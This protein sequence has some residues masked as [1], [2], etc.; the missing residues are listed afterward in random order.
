MNESNPFLTDEWENLPCKTRE[1]RFSADGTPWTDARD[2]VTREQIVEVYRRL[3]ET[4]ETGRQIVAVHQEI[5]AE[6]LG[7]IRKTKWRAARARK[8]AGP[9]SARRSRRKLKG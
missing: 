3:C 5:C 4:G 1:V 2:P 8:P 9:R 6:I 7:L